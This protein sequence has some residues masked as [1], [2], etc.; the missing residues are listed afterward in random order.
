MTDQA[1]WLGR[2]IS[3]PEWGNDCTKKNSSRATKFIEGVEV[4]QNGYAVNVQWYTQKTRGVPE[5]ALDTTL[6]VVQ[7]NCELVLAGFDDQMHQVHGSRTRVP[8]RRTVWSN[9]MDS[10]GLLPSRSSLQTTEGDWH[11]KEF[12]NTSQMDEQARDEATERA[13]LL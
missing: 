8:R 12:G 4:T 10:F 7:S 3:K 2:A 5:H 1:I 9:H 6:P 11:R 13:G